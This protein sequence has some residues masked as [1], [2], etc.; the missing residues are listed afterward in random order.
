ML[1]FPFSASRE[2]GCGPDAQSIRARKAS[3]WAGAKAAAKHGN[4]GARALP[5]TQKLFS[6]SSK[7]IIN[8]LFTFWLKFGQSLF[9][10][11]PSN[12][13]AATL[14]SAGLWRTHPQA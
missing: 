10:S 11:G 12:I 5:K 3:A 14:K 6:K 4:Y 2:P 8:L 13:S 1:A 7:E 9:T